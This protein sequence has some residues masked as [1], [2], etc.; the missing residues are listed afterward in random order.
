MKLEAILSDD[1]TERA[2][3][4]EASSAAPEHERSA[5]AGKII[6]VAR[7]A[8][9]AIESATR[10][11]E[12]ISVHEARFA[13]ACI[14]LS[15]LRVE[16]A[17]SALVRIADEGTPTVKSA[18]AHAL[19]ETRTT[20][21]K[22]VLVH[23]LSD[24]DARDD[25]VLAIGASPWP[26]VLPALIE[27]AEGDEH[28]ARLAATPIA[29]CGATAGPN[30]ASAAADFLLEQLDD[31]AVLAAAV[32]A[33]LR[34]GAGFPGVVARA[35]R[36]AKEPGKRKICGLCLVAAFGDEGNASFLELALAGTRTDEKAARTF[37]GPLLEDTDER[38]RAAAERTWKAL[39][40]GAVT[41]TAR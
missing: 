27:V 9:A 6:A 22:A 24:D 34:L 31:D 13:R 26:E 29:K 28:V 16:V 23:L 1:A 17:K 4:L 35:K 3:A 39:A 12:G 10:S 25:A 40:L 2:V 8:M 5:F 15:S 37:L 38:I 21:G 18:L 19:R 32:D 20:E 7:D 36:L 30:E 14:A 11:G 41:A 33:L